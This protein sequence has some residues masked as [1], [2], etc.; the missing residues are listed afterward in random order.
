MNVFRHHRVA[1]ALAIVAVIAAVYAQA[2]TLA[3]IDF[4]QQT[5]A[6]LAERAGMRCRFVPSC[7]RYAEVVIERDGLVRG[8]WLALRRVARCR[9]GTAFGTVDEP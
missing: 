7:S 1:L 6:P 2:I 8:G 4:Y 5:M 3:G 9:P